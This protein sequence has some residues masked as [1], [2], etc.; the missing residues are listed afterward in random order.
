MW[1]VQRLGLR[2][3][4]QMGK[5]SV[6]RLAQKTRA[7]E[8]ER[9]IAFDGRKVGVMFYKVTV[10]KEDVEVL[11]QELDTERFNQ[12]KLLEKYQKVYPEEA[13]YKVEVQQ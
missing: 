13:G 8:G 3:Q 11:T 9:G 1:S 5:D 12:E 7:D 2:R 6:G 10:K 4:K